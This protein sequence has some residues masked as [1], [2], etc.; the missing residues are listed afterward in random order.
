M[1]AAPAK[2]RR[3]R[4]DARPAIAMRPVVPQGDALRQAIAWLALQGRWTLPLIEEACQRFDMSPADEEF[5]LAEYRR[6]HAEPRR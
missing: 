5:L 2:A 3:V 4:A 6:T 1:A